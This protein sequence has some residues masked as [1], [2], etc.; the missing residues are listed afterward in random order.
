MSKKWGVA[1]GYRNIELADDE[2][3]HW[4][5]IKKYKKNGKWRYVYDYS[6]TT[7]GQ[8]RKSIN[9]NLKKAYDNSNKV[10]TSTNEGQ[11]D[12]YKKQAE[13]YRSAADV[14]QKRY[15]N[16]QKSVNGKID[17]LIETIGTKTVDALNIA[18]D[19]IDAGKKWL[20]NLFK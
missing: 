13:R 1:R 16:Y 12:L 7:A 9:D 14:Q 3:M 11:N 19:I 4:K 10:G 15:N 2:L 5:Y 8:Y 20:K 18:S 17:G 6:A